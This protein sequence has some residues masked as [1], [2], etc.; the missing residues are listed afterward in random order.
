[1]EVGEPEGARE[2]K[3]LFW[4]VAGRGA[5]EKV[6]ADRLVL[7]PDNYYGFILLQF[8]LIF[9]YVLFLGSAKASGSGT[10][11]VSVLLLVVVVMCWRP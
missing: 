6:R 11:L 8:R 10:S 5:G 3:P 9:V 2:Q 7:S 1:V 4:Q